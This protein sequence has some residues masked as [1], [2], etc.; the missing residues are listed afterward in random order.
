MINDIG[1]TERYLI[2]EEKLNGCMNKSSHPGPS[3]HQ[4]AHSRT[5]SGHIMKRFTD[6]HVAV[7]GHNNKKNNLYPTKEVLSKELGHATFK[8]DGSVLRERV[9]NQLWSSY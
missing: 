8:G 3:H 4:A 9:H 5:N 2:H 1:T 7:I 6:G